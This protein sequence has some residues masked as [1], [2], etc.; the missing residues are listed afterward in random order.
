MVESSKGSEEI[1]SRS[2]FGGRVV[3]WDVSRPGV[4]YFFMKYIAALFLVFIIGVVILADAGVLSSYMRNFYGFPYGDKI[5]HFVLFGLLNFFITRAFLTSLPS[6]PRG[7]V[8]LSVGLILALFIVLEE[9]S[10]KFFVTRTFSWLDLSASLL[11]V[12][13]AGWAAYKI[14]RP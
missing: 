13:V 6:R 10:Q 1:I 14:K 11:G 3:R 9:Y 5:G 4:I 2:R 12:L 8:T 7:W